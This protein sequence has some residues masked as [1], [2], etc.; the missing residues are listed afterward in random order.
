[1]NSRHLKSIYLEL[2]ITMLLC[3]LLYV[4]FR[5]EEILINK[6][7]LCFWK[8]ND[9]TAFFSNIKPF[10]P[11]WLVYSLPGAIWLHQFLLIFDLYAPSNSIKNRTLLSIIPL[12]FP[13][14]LELFQKF[15][16][17][18]GTYDGVDLLLYII[19]WLFFIVRINFF[20][21]NYWK[22]HTSYV[23]LSAVGLVFLMAVVLSDVF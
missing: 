10:M 14:C 2:I 4:L 1:M 20:G 18:D 9:I 11:Q 22:I 8:E 15:H 13:L 12:L 5:P 19:A 16:I 17:T 6:L 21:K 23:K 3:A 7:L